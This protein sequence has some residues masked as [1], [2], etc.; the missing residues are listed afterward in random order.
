MLD[1]KVYQISK[2]VYLQYCME[3]NEIQ[4]CVTYIEIMENAGNSI[5]LGDGFFRRYYT[6]FDLENKEVGIAQNK[7]VLTV[8]DILNQPPQDEYLEEDWAPLNY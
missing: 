5:I 3:H 8:E 6:F 1:E 2:E 7:E 4:Y